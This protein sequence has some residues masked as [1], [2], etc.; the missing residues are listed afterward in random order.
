MG[1]SKA[2]SLFSCGLC[3]FAVRI[4]PKNAS[5]ATPLQPPTAQLELALDLWKT[6][7]IFLHDSFF[8]VGP[9]QTKEHVMMQTKIQESV[10]EEVM[11]KE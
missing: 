11:K 10:H 8:S 9:L 4:P 2:V 5:F 3:Y 1:K 6:F 7:V